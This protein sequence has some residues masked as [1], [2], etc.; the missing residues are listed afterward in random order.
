M[1]RTA[2]LVAALAVAAWPALAD[3]LPNGARPLG[4]K[5]LHKLYSGTTLNWETSRAWFAPDGTL[6][7][8]AGKGRLGETLFW[9]TWTVKGNEVCMSGPFRNRITGKEGQFRDCW[10]WYMGADG[11][12]WTLWSV[13]FDGTPPDTRNGYY[14]DEIGRMRRGDG[15]SALFDKLWKG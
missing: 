12:P 15:V 4:A 14:Q 11:K 5:A 8:V 1:F 3:P 6:K 2:S 9:G 7:G 13:H 10:T